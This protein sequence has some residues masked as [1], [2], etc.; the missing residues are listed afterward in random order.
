MPHAGLPHSTPVIS[1]PV[2]E[3]TPTSTAETPSQSH[4]GCRVASHAMFA[5]NAIVS[6]VYMADH[7]ATWK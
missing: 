7:S 6:A 1:P 2:H 5:T 4:L 3:T